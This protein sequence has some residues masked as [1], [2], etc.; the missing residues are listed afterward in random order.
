M[1]VLILFAGTSSI[2]KSIKKYNLNNDT[3]IEYRGLD[4]D[5]KWSHYYTCNILE[6][7][8][9]KELTDWTPDYIHS[10][11]V[12]CEFSQLKSNHTRNLDLG[13]SLIKKTFEIFDFIKSINKN[14]IITCENP[15]NKFARNYN[16]L[17]EIN[18]YETSY[19][20][21][22][23]KY[24]KPTDFWCNYTLNIK[25]ICSRKKKNKNCCEFRKTHSRHEVM[26]GY[27]PIKD[28][29]ITETVYYREL[30]KNEN[31]LKGFTPTHFRYRIPD[32]LCYDII[33]SCI[34]TFNKFD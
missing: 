32:D 19:C 27:K 3:N 22:G 12:C 20:M 23:F 17:M 34:N 21:Y 33:E 13:F 2:E 4:I 16:R 7:D 8:Y 11:F 28:Y 18:R 1:K 6:W 10:S 9:I 31:Y 24:M 29:Q 5:K 25:K 26:I 14:V 15:R 30:K